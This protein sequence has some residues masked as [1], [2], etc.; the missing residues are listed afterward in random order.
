VR[1]FRREVTHGPERACFIGLRAAL[2]QRLHQGILDN[3]WHIVSIHFAVSGIGL[4]IGALGSGGLFASVVSA[5]FGSYAALALGISL[6][7]GGIAR[8][9]Q[10]LL[11]AVVALLCAFGASSPQG[12]HR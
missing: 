1:S 10:W 3:V 11:F 7:L 4:L 2:S 9:P 6:R 5:Q 8:L 12:A